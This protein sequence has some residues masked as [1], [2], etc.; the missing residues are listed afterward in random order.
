MWI[1]TLAPSIIATGAIAVN[2]FVTFGG[3]QVAA[4]GA[5]AIGAS[6]MPAA[7]GQSLPVLALGIGEV[8]SGGAVAV[9]AE[10]VSDASGRGITSAGTAGHWILGHATKATSGAG[11][12]LEY[13]ATPPVQI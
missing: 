8:E 13:L 11:E 9:G 3:A 1:Q 12:I 5:K 7:V 4:A 10:I 6:L 2:R